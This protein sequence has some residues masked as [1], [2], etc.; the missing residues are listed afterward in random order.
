MVENKTR[1]ELAIRMIK[2]G[3]V[4]GKVSDYMTAQVESVPADMNILDVAQKL[5]DGHRRRFLRACPPRRT[6]TRG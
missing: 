1:H 3:Q 2:P 6:P 4:G 5:L